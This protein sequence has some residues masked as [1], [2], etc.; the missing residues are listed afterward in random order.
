MSKETIQRERDWHNKRYANGSDTRQSI[1]RVKIMSIYAHREFIDKI[2]HSRNQKVL[3][4]GCGLGIKKAIKFYSRGSHY[5]GIDL[6]K[7]CINSNKAAAFKEN[8]NA[9]FYV[10]DIHNLK[11]VKNEDFDLII[12]R[13]T[14]HHLNVRK[15][16]PILKK[17]VQKKKGRVLMWEPMGTN[18]LIGVFRLLTPNLRTFDEKPLDFKTLKFIKSYFPNSKFNLHSIFS[19]FLT[20]FCIFSRSKILTK[21]LLGIA[22]FIGKLDSY[23]GY[24]PFLKRL[25]WIVI[26]DC[27][28]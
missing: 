13:G 26:L 18:P 4:I 16:I 21:F 23:L 2:Y 11:F 24:I 19:L 27:K 28:L 25:S 20:P 3:D 14:L 8:I 17:L 6:S 22:F 7:E 5:I 10:E 15:V 9:D 12:I 1:N